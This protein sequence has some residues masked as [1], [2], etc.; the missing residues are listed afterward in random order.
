MH[1][2]GCMH[3]EKCNMAG[4]P[5][6]LSCY[7]V[8]AVHVCERHSA[9][10]TTDVPYLVTSRHQL[11]VCVTSRPHLLYSCN[12]RKKW[13]R[14]LTGCR[15]PLELVAQLTLLSCACCS[16][17][18]ASD[19]DATSTQACCVLKPATDRK[20][21]LGTDMVKE[22]ERCSAASWMMRRDMHPAGRAPSRDHTG[23]RPSMHLITPGSIAIVVSA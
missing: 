10:C 22:S 23:C 1:V 9:G 3:G 8:L 20:G 16:A 4:M 5:W 13:A 7:Q 12:W 2:M 11:Q 15:R 6:M 18:C 17:S 19:R 21:N 14:L